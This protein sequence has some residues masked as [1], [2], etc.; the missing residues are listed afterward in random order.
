MKSAEQKRQD[1]CYGKLKCWGNVLG[2]CPVASECI[3]ISK[4]ICPKCGDPL[5]KEYMVQMF[6]DVTTFECKFC[7]FN[8][9]MKGK[10]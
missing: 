7:G 3:C 1:D 2:V 6:R 8:V 4:D 10:I 9:T 5:T